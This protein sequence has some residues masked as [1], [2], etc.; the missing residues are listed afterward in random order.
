MSVTA[1]LLEVRALQKH[2]VLGGGLFGGGGVP[3][4]AVDGV[5]FDIGRGEVLGLVGESGSGK[6]TVGRTVLRLVNPTNGSIRFDGTDITRLTRGQLRPLRRHMQLIFQDP[7]GSLSPR[8]RVGRIVGAPLAIHEPT[9]PHG[10]RTARV[11][12]ALNLVGLPA[13][14]ADRFPP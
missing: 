3:V 5:S 8:M 10:I 7:Y 4:R 11:A 1:P 13:G 2:Y 6:T 9:L 12:E 14:A